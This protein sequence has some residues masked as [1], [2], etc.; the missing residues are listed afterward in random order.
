MKNQNKNRLGFTLIELLVVVLI[1]GIL[2]AVALPQYTKSVMKARY[3]TLKDLTRGLADAEE[4]YFMAN[5]S[6][7]GDIGELDIDL[8]AGFT[9]KTEDA[10]EDTK[11]QRYLSQDGKVECSLNG[12][13][14][15]GYAACKNTEH[16]LRYHIFLD[17][18]ENAN[19]GKIFCA[20]MADAS[21]IKTKQAFSFCKAETKN[22][23]DPST[24]SVGGWKFWVYKN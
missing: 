16:G 6:Y 15:Q 18:S 12:N 7:T 5:N 24:T 20:A 10:P 2:S 4:R 23:M 9:L 3:G 22:N 8:P 13:K 1:I 14:V 21:D 11:H 19:K 17:S